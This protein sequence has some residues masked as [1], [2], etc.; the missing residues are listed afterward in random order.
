M[1]A[2]HTIYA[3][4][5]CVYDL[6]VPILRMIVWIIKQYQILH[7]DKYATQHTAHS[8]LWVY[9]KENVPMY[10]TA[11]YILPILS[12]CICKRNN[13]MKICSYLLLYERLY[14]LYGVGHLIWQGT[15]EKAQPQMPWLCATITA[16]AGVHSKINNKQWNTHNKMKLKYVAHVA[17]S[18]A[19]LSLYLS[20]IP[21]SHTSKRQTHSTTTVEHFSSVRCSANTSATTQSHMAQTKTE[22][23]N[24]KINK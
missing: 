7:A 9:N 4:C 3:V 16:L 17:E 10:A 5:L 14:Y 2:L 1:N 20:G 15:G 19:S 21:R 12:S 24:T 11:F 23:N 6:G 8:T 18:K 13:H 22:Q